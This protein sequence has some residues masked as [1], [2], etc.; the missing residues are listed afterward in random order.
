VPYLFTSPEASDTARLS[1]DRGVDRRTDRLMRHVRQPGRGQHLVREDGVWTELTGELTTDREA[2]AD[3][4]LYGG[5]TTLVD[6]DTAAELTAAGF[7]E[8]LTPA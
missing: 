1:Y 6:D 4:V 2:A 7:A 8:N 5:H 3:L